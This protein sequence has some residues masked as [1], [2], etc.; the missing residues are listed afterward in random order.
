[1]R[2]SLKPLL[3][4]ALFIT[5]VGLA[6]RL[7]ILYF[8]WHSTPLTQPNEIYGYEFGCVA[9][10]IASGNGFS[11]PSPFVTTGPTAWFG[12]IYPYML[13]WIFK[14]WGIYSQESHIL[15]KVL[16]CLF[17]ALTV[18]PIY[19]IAKRAFGPVVAIYASWVW[20]ILP[21]AWHLPIASDGDAVLSA[22]WLALIIQATFALAKSHALAGWAA[23]GALWAVGA[24]LNTSL[25]LLFPF[26]LGWL[27]WKAQN[28]SAPWLRH[29][30]VAVLVF[31]LGMVP[32]SIRNYRVFHKFV[33]VRSC[34]GLVL[35]LGNNPHGTGVDALWIMPVSNRTEAESYKRMGEIAY[36]GEKQREALDFIRSHPALT[37]ANILR[38]IGSFWFEVSDRPNNVWSKNPPYIKALHAL[39]AVMILFAWF[40]TSL[41]VRKRNTEAIPY[42][43]AILVYP[44][45]FYLTYS[46]V[47]FSFPMEPLLVVLAAYGVIQTIAWLLE[48]RAL[49]R[50]ST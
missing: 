4:S 35:W 6:L 18:F 37:L 16:N 48:R 28:L 40:G 30:T 41:A 34:F 7:A 32:W 12:P 13:G 1:M 20:V 22:L 2:G 24:L 19:A 3:S 15:L 44:L 29:V 43:I 47:R 26:L 14:T 31:L 27:V 11:S 25:L 21:I 17:S 42:L 45:V 10:S 23:Y 9:K 39:N 46:T 36:M 8:V 50:P 33:P 38:R 5:G 49:G